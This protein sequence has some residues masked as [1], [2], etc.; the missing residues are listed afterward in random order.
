MW[1]LFWMPSLQAT[2]IYRAELSNGTVLYTDAPS[3]Q[4][5]Q[6]FLLDKKPLPHRNKVNV[7]NVPLLDSWD[8]EILSASAQYGV[9]AE[10]IK[11]VCLAESGMNPRALSPAGARG[12]MQLMPDTAR[13]LGVKDPWDPVQNIDGGTRYLRSLMQRF[14]QLA[15]AVAGY[16]A[17]PKNVEK[18]R[19][20]PPFTET[21]NYVVRVLDLYDHLRDAR[22][23]VP[24]DVPAYEAGR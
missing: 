12:L 8:D 16:N 22:P 2:D 4:G 15:H 6:P 24:E 17:G 13:G 10:L 11:A 21:Q 3:G 7:R 14:P 23:V 18:H 20:I 5:F 19:G 1:W 9:P